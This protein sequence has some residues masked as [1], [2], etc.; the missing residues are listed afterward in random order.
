MET[1]DRPCEP[2]WLSVRVTTC[3]DMCLSDLNYPSFNKLLLK[4]RSDYLKRRIPFLEDEDP[5]KRAMDLCRTANTK[6]YRSL[7]L[8]LN[9]QEDPI[10]EDITSRIDA[11]KRKAVT[12]S[13]RETYL[14]MNPT[15]SIHP[16]YNAYVPEYLRIAFT[17]LRLV[18]HSLRV[19]T[20]RWAR[21]DRE[22]RLCQC[23]TGR[24]Q[25]EKH[26]LFD[27]PLTYHIR[28]GTGVNTFTELFKQEDYVAM[29]KHIYKC[30]KYFS[31]L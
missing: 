31:T 6:G 20:G 18:S 7:M 13:K 16:M 10:N 21:I 15:G 2:R 28:A 29:C 24:V 19:E 4:R 14:T 12:S 3:T 9:L 26:V 22:R 23:N 5:L 17:R 27:C 1:Y 11:I 25:D 30:L 8:A